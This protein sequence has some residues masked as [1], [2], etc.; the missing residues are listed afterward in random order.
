MSLYVVVMPRVDLIWVF[1]FFVVGCYGRVGGMRIHITS[2]A[3]S[4]E[5]MLSPFLHPF[6]PS[7]KTVMIL[8]DFCS[9]ADWARASLS[10][11]LPKK[12]KKRGGTG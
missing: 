9:I 7:G 1:F 6:L 2:V 11:L 10:P 12:K 8:F 4:I 3:V 5:S